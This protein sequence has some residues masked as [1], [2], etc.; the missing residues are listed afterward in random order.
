[1]TWD[2]H[3]L[4]RYK[5]R[6]NIKTISPQRNVQ[7]PYSENLTSRQ[8]FSQVVMS[9]LHR[10]PPSAPGTASVARALSTWTQVFKRSD[11]GAQGVEWL[12]RMP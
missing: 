4:F 1:M 12:E 3:V 8:D 2:F 11:Y 7:S 6:E 5:D 9:Q 10:P